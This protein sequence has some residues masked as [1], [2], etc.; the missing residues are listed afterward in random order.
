MECIYVI[1]AEL[2]MALVPRI[3]RKSDNH[4]GGRDHQNIDETVNGPYAIV[5]ENT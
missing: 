4:H 1:I 3:T 2:V 5:V